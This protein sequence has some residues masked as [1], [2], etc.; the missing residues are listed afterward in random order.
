MDVFFDCEFTKL[1]YA[2]DGYPGLISICCA[3]EDGRRTFYAELTNTWQRGNCSQF[4]LDNVLPLLS[5]GDCQMTDAQCALNLK[6]W[7]EDLT[8][9][10]ILRSDNPG[11]DW[12]WVKELFD[13]FGCWPKNLRRS[14]GSIYFDDE[15]QQNVYQVALEMYWQTPLMAAHRHHALYDANSLVFAWWHAH[16]REMSEEAFLDLMKNLSLNSLE[17]GDIGCTY[18]SN[19]MS[20]LK[21]ERERTL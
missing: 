7:I 20:N 6:S 8:D 17:D 11:I 3:S 9:E 1:P 16:A 19:L 13:F 15:A 4:V 21:R 18:W 10:V 12:P 2:R 5:G 14:C